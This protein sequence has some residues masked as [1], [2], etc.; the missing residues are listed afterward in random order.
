MPFTRRLLPT[1]RN[2]IADDI[3]RHAPVDAH[4]RGSVENAFA[5]A[6]AGAMHMLYGGLDYFSKQL[7][8][9]TADDE[10][11]LRRAAVF[12]ITLIPAV[13]AVGPV[14]FTGNDGGTVLAG[15]QLSIGNTVYTTD[16]EAV[17][18]GGVASAQ[19]TAVLQ[20]KDDSDALDGAGTNQNAGTSLSFITPVANVDST[21]TV[22][23]GGL[24]NGADAETIERLKARFAE[25]K[26][27][28]PRGGSTADYVAWCKQASADVTR[29]FVNG[30]LDNAL[31]TEYGSVLIFPV[32]DNLPSPIPN[33]ALLT[34]IADYLNQS[35][36]RPVGAKNIYVQ[37]LTQTGLNMVFSSL[38][39]NSATVQAAIDAEVADLLL[40]EG[41]PGQTLLLSHL[42]EAISNAAGEENFVLTSPAAD[43]VLPVNELLVLGATTWP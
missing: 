25:R 43:I 17:I 35:S 41:N 39:P 13:P 1:L 5:N 37:A 40:R 33:G 29:V 6:L 3:E 15:T 8:D 16:A 30:H 24:T 4:Q 9:N 18:A 27:T 26:Q 34:T 19:V 23:T 42:R 38:T 36:I 22:G 20:P 12:G 32:T 7:F 28:P 31:A 11:I 21:A 14:D 2:D 10:F